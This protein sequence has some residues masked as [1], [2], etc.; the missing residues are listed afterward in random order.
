MGKV[1]PSIC[2]N[3]TFSNK[4]KYSKSLQNQKKNVI[5]LDQKTTGYK[6]R[7]WFKKTGLFPNYFLNHFL[8][9]LFF[10]NLIFTNMHKKY[11]NNF[12]TFF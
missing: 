11:E 7:Y 1:Y 3:N 5:K 12:L 4:H 9:N 10:I 6:T 2:Q 8:F